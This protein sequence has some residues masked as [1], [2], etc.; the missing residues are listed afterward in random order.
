MV[1]HSYIFPTTNWPII[2]FFYATVGQYVIKHF[3]DEVHINPVTITMSFMFFPFRIY[4]KHSLLINMAEVIN[5]PKFRDKSV[6]LLK[7]TA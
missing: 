4:R 5:K 2:D 1:D 7:E 6:E 3:R